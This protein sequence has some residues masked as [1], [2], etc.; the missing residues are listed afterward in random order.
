MAFLTLFTAPKP[1][2]DPHIATIQWNAIQSWTRLEDVEVLLMGNDE[3]VAEAA[4]ALGVRHLPGVKCNR[5]GTPLLSSM[6]QLARAKGEAAMLGVVNADILLLPDFLAAAHRVQEL[7]AEFVL[8]GQ[9]WDL[10]V[11]A[12]IDFSGDWQERLRSAVR[13]QARLHRPAGSDFFLFPRG[14]YTRIPDFSIGRAG[15][16]NWM[17]YEARR[18]RRLVIDGTPSMM[19]IHQNHDYRHLPGGRPHHTHPDSDE[20]IRLAGGQAAIRYTILDATHQ[21]VGGRLVRPKMTSTRLARNIE[22]FLRTVFFFLPGGMVEEI[23]RPKRWRK[24]IQRTLKGKK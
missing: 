13:S 16:D 11:S 5:S 3:G 9:R 7:N 10:D 23:A 4:E 21:L 24:R 18:E 17:I 22:V 1:F 6:F 19:V 2:T 12:R 15:W 20:N 14:C 8:L